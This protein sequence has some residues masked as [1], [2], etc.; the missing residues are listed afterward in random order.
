MTRKAIVHD[1]IQR[2]YVYYR[3]EPVGWNSAPEFRPQLTRKQVLELGVFGGKYM[4][5]GAGE[6]PAHSFT[7]ARLS[8]HRCTGL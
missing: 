2:E 5:D 7:R 8:R 6:I 4:T 1:N 3:T